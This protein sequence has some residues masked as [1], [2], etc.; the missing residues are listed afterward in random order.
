MGSKIIDSAKGG[1][2]ARQFI[3]NAQEGLVK[4]ART[5]GKVLDSMRNGFNQMM[6]C[7]QLAMEGIGALDDTSKT[8]D[9]FE[10]IVK[11]IVKPTKANNTTSMPSGKVATHSGVN[12]KNSVEPEKIE[13]VV[14]DIEDT[15][16][17]IEGAAK[18]VSTDALNHS[19]IV[20]FTYNPKTGKVSKMKGGGHGQ[21]NID[22]L[23]K[24]GIEYNI[25]KEYP[26]GVRVGNVPNHKVKAK[27]SGMEQSWFPETWSESDIQA[28]REKIANMSGNTGVADGV[29]VFGEYNGV[30]VGVIRTDGKIATVFPD[31][32]MQQGN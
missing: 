11:N 26:N 32:A 6:P 16:K 29:A 28:A 1:K 15:A 27:R 21:A 10:N 3:K 2:V 25:E 20:D 12:I 24:N 14:D 30:R 18:A 22:F 31:S 17:A 19:N 7:P 5:A 23:D 13:K 9:R 4:K 8:A